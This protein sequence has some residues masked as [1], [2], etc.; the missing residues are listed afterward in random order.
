MARGSAA[1]G[2]AFLQIPGVAASVHERHGPSQ[3]SLQQTP[4]TQKPL[5]HSVAALQVWPVPF[6]PQLIL[7]V[8]QLLPG[9]QSPL[10]AQ[11]A[12]Q[13]PSLQPK[14]SQRMVPADWQTPLPSQAL[15]RVS[16]GPLQAA[17]RQTGPAASR[18]Q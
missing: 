8:S 10:T 18:A 7:V 13:R 12:L 15:A 17:A 4:S 3:A 14:G 16:V 2:A 9:A 6:R 5:S 11:V 1:P